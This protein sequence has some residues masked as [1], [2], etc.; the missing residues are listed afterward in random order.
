MPGGCEAVGPGFE[1]RAESRGDLRVLRGE[2]VL[3]LAV[4]GEVV[5]V[6]AITAA[7]EFPVSFANGALGHPAPVERV[8]RRGFVFAGEVGQQIDSVE[9]S[10]SRGFSRIFRVA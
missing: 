7:Q 6:F 1:L 4:G 2:V 10:W 5:E 8:V 3:L 9:V